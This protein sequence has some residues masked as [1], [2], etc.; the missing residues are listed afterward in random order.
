LLYITHTVT[1]VTLLLPVLCGLDLVVHYLLLQFTHLF[2]SDRYLVVTLD[3]C[4]CSTH[5]PY[6][7]WC[8]LHFH[9]LPLLLL[10][11]L[12]H[13]IHFIPHLIAPPVKDLHYHT[14]YTRTTVTLQ[15]T[16]YSDPIQV[17]PSYWD[18]IVLLPVVDPTLT[19][20]H[21]DYSSRAFGRYTHVTTD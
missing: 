14:A 7:I 2:Y 21:W 17:D 4:Y 12:P 5:L 15:F 8:T 1:F 11:T 18:I 6:T 16:L 9:T 13:L 20:L 10:Y 19:T 3:P